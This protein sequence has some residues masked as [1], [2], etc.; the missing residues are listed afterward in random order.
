MPIDHT[1]LAVVL[2]RNCKRLRNEIGITQD[3]LARYARDFGLRWKASM[4]GDFEAGRSAPTFATVLT[5]TLALQR[6][7][8]DIEEQRRIVGVGLADL[9]T[10]KGLVDLTDALEVWGSELV[11]LCQGRVVTIGP[12][13]QRWSAEPHP[14]PSIQMARTLHQ[15]TGPEAMRLMMIKG[16]AA[17]RE[18]ELELGVTFDELTEMLMRSGLAEQRL[19]RQLDIKPAAL[20]AASFRL[21]QKT[22]S[23][24]RDR[25]A[26][27]DANQQ[28]KGRISRELRGELEQELSRGDD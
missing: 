26:G 18:R 11:E 12:D 1:P 22:F 17:V 14:S 13:P 28:K 25:R 19:A 8:A 21:W 5:V 9:V 20:A 4:V 27:T 3:E 2:G 16:K 6:A 15:L 23:E 7:L 10:T 24:E